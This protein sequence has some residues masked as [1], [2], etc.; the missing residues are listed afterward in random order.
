MAES[1]FSDITESSDPR[2]SADRVW[3]DFEVDENLVFSTTSAESRACT[4]NTVVTL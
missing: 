4:L 3:K 1:Y 2:P